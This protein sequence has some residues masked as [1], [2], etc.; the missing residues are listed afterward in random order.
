MD[1]DDARLLCTM[2]AWGDGRFPV[3]AD[4]DASGSVVAARVSFPDTAR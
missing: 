4:L 1:I 3:S 2:T